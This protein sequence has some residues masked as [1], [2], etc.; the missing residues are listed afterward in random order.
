MFLVDTN[1]LSEQMRNAPDGRVMAWLER[2]PVIAV[3]VI[4]VMELDS[5]VTRAPA[6][7]RD[8]LRQWLDD[9]LASPAHEF[10][11]VTI[12]IARAAGQLEARMLTRGKQRSAPDLLIAATALTHGAVLVTR[13]TRDFEGMG[14]GLLNPFD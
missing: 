13:N 9:L 3:S 12:A 11:P 4:T 1:V 5:G 10:L 6:A 7:K 2:Q 8:P 14:V